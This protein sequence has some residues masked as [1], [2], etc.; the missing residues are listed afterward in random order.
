MMKNFMLLQ[1]LLSHRYGSRTLNSN[2]NEKEYE[3][4]KTELNS[5]NINLLEIFY[6]FDENNIENKEYKLKN[7]NSIIKEL[8]V[9]LNYR[10][11]KNISKNIKFNCIQVEKKVFEEEYE[12][13]LMILMREAVDKCYKKNQLSTIQRNI[14]FNSGIKSQNFD[15]DRYQLWGDNIPNILISLLF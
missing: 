13:K 5:D 10:A 8:K 4:I 11:L 1:G 3:L 14:Y 7:V 6:E 15:F 2:I 12:N 9:L